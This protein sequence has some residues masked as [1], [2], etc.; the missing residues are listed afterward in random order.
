MAGHG[1]CAASGRVV[2]LVA[3]GA[4]IAWAAWGGTGEHHFGAPQ[5]WAGDGASVIVVGDINGGG[6]PDLVVANRD[7]LAPGVT[8][9]LNDGAGEELQPVT[10]PLDHE[11]DCVIVGDGCVNVFDLASLAADLGCTADPG[12]KR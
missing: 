11:V 7:P 5:W 9:L 10:Y 8:V 3:G 6:S 2:S 12:A 4:I 1:S